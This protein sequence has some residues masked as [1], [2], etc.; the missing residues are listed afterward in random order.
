MT[1]KL[2]M[3]GMT[4]SQKSQR[5][6]PKYKNQRWVLCD[7]WVEVVD[8]CQADILLQMMHGVA[9]EDRYEPKRCHT[10]QRWVP[11]NDFKVK[12]LCDEGT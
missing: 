12:D 3:G 1:Q 6:E 2:K 4:V 8:G 11:R 5:F 7:K 9:L 10:R